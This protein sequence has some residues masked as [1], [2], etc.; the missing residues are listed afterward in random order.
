M[1]ITH[2]HVPGNGTVHHCD[3]RRGDHLAVIVSAGGQRTIILYDRQNP[4]TPAVTLELD[5][6]EADQL[7]D[8]LHSR[9]LADRLAAVEQRLEDI[10]HE[11]RR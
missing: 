8:L 6:V 3:T 7:A 5:Q 2:T 10:L 1:N 9:P 11:A 4:D